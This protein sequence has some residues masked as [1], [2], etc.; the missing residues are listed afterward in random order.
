MAT[1]FAVDTKDA[2]TN[3]KAAAVNMENIHEKIAAALGTMKENV[4]ITDIAV[5]PMSKKV[6][7]AVQHS[8][9][10]PA[11]L[12]IDNEK[13]MSLPLKDIKSSQIA[14][15]D[16]VE[17][18]AKDQRGRPLRVSTITDIGFHNGKVLVSGLSNK[19]FGSTLRSIP[20]P[21]TNKQD[22][23]SLEIYHTAHGRYETA[24]PIKTFTTGKINGKDYLIASY[25]C[26][27][28]VLFPLDE[29]KPGSHV[30]GR[31]VAEM[32]SGNTPLDMITVK[33]GS[34]SFLMMA[35]TSKPL[36]RLNIKSIEAFEGTLTEK[37]SGT[38]GAGFDQLSLKDVLQL[39]RLDNDHVVMIQKKSNGNIDLWTAADDNLQ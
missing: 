15:N 16:V 22:Q 7:I 27:P 33:K 23:T 29:L 24:A 12:K 32:G 13:I 26:T 1:I 4:T 6:Y 30:K 3:Q 11:I 20:F 14:L 38:A 17:Q 35:N 28:L 36:A 10:S 21:F 18:D 2:K 37:V 19:E 5:N 39:D 31:T 8:S 34:E 9:G 25:T